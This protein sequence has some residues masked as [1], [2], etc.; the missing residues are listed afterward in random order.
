MLYVFFHCK[1]LY[2]KFCVQE[3]TVS[4]VLHQS[5]FSNI[6]MYLLRM[7]GALGLQEENK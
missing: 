6:K 3:V 5:G 7:W 1:K 4:S 2:N